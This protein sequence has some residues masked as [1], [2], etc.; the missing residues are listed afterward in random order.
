MGHKT[1]QLSD[2]QTCPEISITHPLTSAHPPP[3]TSVSAPGEDRKKEQ[4]P[5]LAL[6]T[7]LF[8]P[9]KLLLPIQKRTTSSHHGGTA[10]SETKNFFQ[11]LWLVLET[12]FYI[13]VSA[14]SFHILKVTFAIEVRTF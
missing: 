2:I 12:L 14:Y 11:I 10:F 13:S 1:H 3:P 8:S 4:S 9:C 6:K 5:P 7:L